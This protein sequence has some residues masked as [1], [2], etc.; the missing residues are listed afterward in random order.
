MKIKLISLIA[1]CAVM[2]SFAGCS[3][4]N[5]KDDTNETYNFEEA[6]QNYGDVVH[7]DDESFSL[8]MEYDSRFIT[9]EIASSVADYFYS[10]QTKNL[11]L[12][13]TV[14][15]EEYQSY[16]IN[17][18]YSSENYDEQSFLDA[19][20]NGIKNQSGDNFNI[21]LISI[22]D[23]DNDE[24]TSGAKDI[25]QLLSDL[26][27]EDYSKKVTESAKLTL[28]F[29]VSAGGEEYEKTNQNIFILKIDDKYKIVTA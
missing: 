24:D 1:A 15:I 13:K 2:C 8:P 12:Y 19:L 28:A 23:F 10:V 7:D 14:T 4:N 3:S 25:I 22:T 11:E 6:D 27:N 29:T 5:K 20:Y 21:K 16:L 17:D 18:V 26:T 9:N